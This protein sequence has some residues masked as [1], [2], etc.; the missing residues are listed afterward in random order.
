M[1]CHIRKHLMFGNVTLQRIQ[2]MESKFTKAQAYLF[3]PLPFTVF[4]GNT[5]VASEESSSV[6]RSRRQNAQ[7]KQGDKK[8]IDTLW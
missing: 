8:G 5:G 6:L 4:L 1:L 3:G 2:V 7:A